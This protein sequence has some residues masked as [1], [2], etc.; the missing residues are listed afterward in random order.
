MHEKIQV[1]LV[2]CL[3]AYSIYGA[4]TL[5]S[6]RKGSYIDGF[7]FWLV[8]ISYLLINATAVIILAFRG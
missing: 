1:F 7:W 3:I 5:Y 8:S 6:I 4:Y 2:G